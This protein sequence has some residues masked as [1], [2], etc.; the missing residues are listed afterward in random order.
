M[1]THPALEFIIQK[2]DETRPLWEP[3]LANPPPN[4]ALL[5]DESCGLGVAME[6]GYPAPSDGVKTGYAGGIGPH[7]ILKVLEDVTT[8]AAQEG[9]GVWVDMESRLRS[10]ING[11]DCF[12]GHKAFVVLQQAQEFLAKD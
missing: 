10:D 12:D 2:N 8:A 7:N 1:R 6:G 5:V 3:L 11:S 9:K 4:M